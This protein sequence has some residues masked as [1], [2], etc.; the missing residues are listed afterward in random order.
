MERFIGRTL[1][2]GQQCGNHIRKIFGVLV[3]CRKGKVALKVAGLS[4]PVE[5]QIGQDK[6]VPFYLGPAIPADCGMEC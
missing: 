1:G 6:W 5:F 4:E 3:G 2:L